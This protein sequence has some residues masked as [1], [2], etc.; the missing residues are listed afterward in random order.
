METPDFRIATKSS[1]MSFVKSIADY[2]TFDWESYTPLGPQDN[3]FN[4]FL[5]SL[6]PHFLPT[7]VPF[8]AVILYWFLSEPVFCKIRGLCLGT[9]GYPLPPV[10]DKNG[11][12]LKAE[13][14]PLDNFMNYVTI[15]HSFAL[16]VYS[17]WTCV[18]AFSIV[19]TAYAGYTNKGMSAWDA[20]M[21][22]SCDEDSS[23][24]QEANLGFWVGH[25][26]L[27]KYWEFLDTWILHLT[28]KKPILLQTYHH[29]GIVI[30]MWSFVVSRN[31]ACALTTTVLNSGIHTVMYLYYT[32]TA[33]KWPS[34]QVTDKETG[35]VKTIEPIRKLD[36]II[37]ACQLT[38]FVCGISMTLPTYFYASTPGCGNPARQFGTVGIH[39]YTII[40]MHMFWE[41]YKGKYHKPKSA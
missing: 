25:F 26:Y 23:L 20:Y 9:D 6:Y 40:L 15:L 18:N 29:A 37:T 7:V 30:L 10:L 2:A 38:Q 28:G 8:G 27:S 4:S 19:S 22:M 36:F 12:P 31:T 41:F 14:T 39:V 21:A 34:Y 3:D 32:L 24:W 11:K 33:L 17:A 35:V 16:F 13:K 1:R 5:A